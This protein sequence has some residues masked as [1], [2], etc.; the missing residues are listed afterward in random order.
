MAS[1]RMWRLYLVPE[2]SYEGAIRLLKPTLAEMAL[3][4]HHTDALCESHTSPSRDFG[5]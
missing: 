4:V 2:V 1:A 3:S 5:Q